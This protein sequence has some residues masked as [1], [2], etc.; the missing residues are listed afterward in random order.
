MLSDEGIGKMLLSERRVGPVRELEKVYKETCSKCPELSVKWCE[1]IPDSL[2]NGDVIFFPE[3]RENQDFSAWADSLD[4]SVKIICAQELC[5][6]VS[7]V[8]RY[9]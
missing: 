8:Y 4:E 1:G 2:E 5:H 9:R 3:H 6:Q 7:A